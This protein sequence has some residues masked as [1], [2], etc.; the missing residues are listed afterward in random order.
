MLLHS[1][2]HSRAKLVHFEPGKLELERGDLMLTEKRQEIAGLLREWTG[3]PWQVVESDQEG[4]PSPHR[5]RGDRQGAA[6]GR[7]PPMIRG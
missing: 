2:L 4:D 5:A 3:E 7:T 1:W 6:P